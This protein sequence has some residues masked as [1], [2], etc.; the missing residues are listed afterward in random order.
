MRETVSKTTKIIFEIRVVRIKGE[1]LSFQNPE[2][3][4]LQP[5][6]L[7]SLFLEKSESLEVREKVKTFFT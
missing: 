3:Y 5:P 7:L 4:F 6:S 1:S 2:M